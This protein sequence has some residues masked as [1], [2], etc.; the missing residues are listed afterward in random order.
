M[1]SG[2]IALTSD[3]ADIVCVTAHGLRRYQLSSQS[4]IWTNKGIPS[5]TTALRITN[6][7]KSILVG[8][9]RGELRLVS[10]DSGNEIFR[11]SAHAWHV[12]GIDVSPD[13]RYCITSSL[14]EVIRLWDLSKGSQINEY[15]GDKGSVNAL[16]FRDSGTSFVA[17]VGTPMHIQALKKEY[18]PKPICQLDLWSLKSNTRTASFSERGG[19][20]TCILALSRE[21]CLTGSDDRLLRVWDLK[22]GQITARLKGIWEPGAT[23]VASM[24]DGR[25]VLGGSPDG[26]VRI[27]DLARLR[28]HGKPTKGAFEH[29]GFV[30]HERGICSVAVSPSGQTLASTSGSEVRL[31]RLEGINPNLVWRKDFG[32][33]RSVLLIDDQT[34][35]FTDRDNAIFLLNC[36]LGQVKLKLVGH[37]ADINCLSRGRSDEIISAGGARA[38]FTDEPRSDDNS[39]CLWNVGDGAQRL[40]MPQKSPVDT[41]AYLENNLIVSNEG[42]KINV[43]DAAT[44]SHVTTLESHEG[45]ITVLLTVDGHYI[46]CGGSGTTIRLWD[47]LAG[48]EIRRFEGVDSVAGLA[49]VGEEYLV[50]ALRRPVLQLWN[51]GTG[52]LL[53]RLDGDAGFSAIAALPNSANLFV[54]D[55]LGRLH[56]IGIHC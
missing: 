46:L 11:L 34:L 15:H 3:G 4:E 47:V 33:V 17:A 21:K 13:N 22:S 35:A 1:S 55:E 45:R 16:L 32:W 49:V 20:I 38:W 10:M 8:T 43:W 7:S 12:F 27:W 6:D 41:V 42:A 18:H 30:A 44:G 48:R 53:A 56:L 29:R 52:E 25:R 40:R 14:D 31:W 26:V 19:A 50:S 2:T 36:D 9:S 51:L 23:H 54:G 39:I 28:D 37:R 5:D 24:G